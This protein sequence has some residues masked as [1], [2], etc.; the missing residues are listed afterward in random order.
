MLVVLECV[1]P[2]EQPEP[3]LERAV[4][5]AKETNAALELFVSEIIWRSLAPLL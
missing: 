5:L 1:D 3:A 2:S 4:F